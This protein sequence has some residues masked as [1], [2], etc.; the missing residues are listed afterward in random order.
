MAQSNTDR[1][2]QPKYKAKTQQQQLKKATSTSMND[3][4]VH[5]NS[6]GGIK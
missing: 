5:A 2:E 4:K 3:W 6:G 1:E